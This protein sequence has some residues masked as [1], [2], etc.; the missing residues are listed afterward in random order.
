MVYTQEGN[1]CLLAPGN[2]VLKPG[3]IHVWTMSLDLAAPVVD[4]QLSHLS[5]DETARA[6]RFAFARDRNRFIVGRSCLRSLLALY[7]NVAPRATRICYNE[8]G[9]PFVP[10]TSNRREITFNLAHSGGMAIYGFTL[11]RKIGI[12]VEEVR[13]GLQINDLAERF[14]SPWEAACLRN[15]DPAFRTKAFFDCWTRKEAFVKALGMGLSLDLAQ[16]DVSFREGDRPAVLRTEWDPAEAWRWSLVAF[17]VG[18]RHAA[19]LA[20][21]G[22]VER[23]RTGDAAEVFSLSQTTSASLVP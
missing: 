4:Q 13:T 11:Q 8:Y 23:I 12:D 18:N 1:A 16:F 20:V 6:A 3:E 17:K 14:F 21:E 10:A 9:K 22:R 2:A 7:L 5:T 19:A 15:I